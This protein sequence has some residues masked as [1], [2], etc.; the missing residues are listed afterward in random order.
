MFCF[1]ACKDKKSLRPVESDSDRS[2]APYIPS[3]GGG[4]SGLE[5]GQKG[6]VHGGAS[7]VVSGTGFSVQNEGLTLRVGDTIE[8]VSVNKADDSYTFTFNSSNSR[9]TKTVTVPIKP[10]Q[11]SIDVSRDGQYLGTLE[12]H[13]LHVYVFYGDGEN[14]TIN[15]QLYYRVSTDSGVRDSSDFMMFEPTLFKSGV[16]KSGNPYSPYGG[17]F[18]I[19]P[20]TIVWSFSGKGVRNK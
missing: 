2:N 18:F 17:K 7:V 9:Q 3:V 20:K 6:G 11:R 4:G 13:E 1:S 5:K 14:R 16:I 10:N 15:G 12:G 19:D 8:L